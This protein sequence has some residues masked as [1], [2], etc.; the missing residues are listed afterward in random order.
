MFSKKIN[1]ARLI[2]CCLICISD[3]SP[4]LYIVCKEYDKKVDLLIWSCSK[5]FF[6]NVIWLEK[7]NSH[8]GMELLTARYNN[9]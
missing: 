3:R 9:N 2:G 1:T 4:R 6:K 5:P 7:P 8:Y